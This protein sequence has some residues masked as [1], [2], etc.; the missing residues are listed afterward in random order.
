MKIIFLNSWYFLYHL[1]PLFHFWLSS[2]N[3]FWR[4]LIYLIQ[5][6]SRYFLICITL[7]TNING[8]LLY[9]YEELKCIM[10][11]TLMSSF[12]NYNNIGTM[13]VLLQFYIDNVNRWRK[14]YIS[15]KHNNIY[16]IRL[17]WRELI[18]KNNRSG[19]GMTLYSNN[20]YIIL[21]W[22]RICPFKQCKLLV[23]FV[24]WITIY[25]IN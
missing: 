1:R 17:S 14:K 13:C 7:C 15:H 2:R 25:W 3:F 21:S 6:S 19:R 4:I 8:L 22:I 11:S 16:L 5:N 20:N 12:T 23:F 18:N 10:N 24:R 9:Y